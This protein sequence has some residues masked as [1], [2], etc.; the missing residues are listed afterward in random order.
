M[1]KKQRK[2]AKKASVPVTSYSEVRIASVLHRRFNHN[3]PDYLDRKAEHDI[4]VFLYNGFQVGGKYYS[5][6]EG[7][8]YLGKCRTCVEN[9]AMKEDLLLR[10]PVAFKVDPKSVLP[11]GKLGGELHIIDPIQLLTL[12]RM[13]DNN[14]MFKRMQT[15]LW[16]DEQ[17]N[18]L[19]KGRCSVKAWI[20][21]G[22]DQYWRDKPIHPRHPSLK[23][24]QP[25][26]EWP[27]SKSLAADEIPWIM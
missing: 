27:A 11:K 14:K 15:W 23:F 9:F 10:Q 7:A 1:T 6:I 22:C 24:N 25:L 5:V 20:Y 26:L 19:V 18:P 3:T 21:L 2:L 16:M 8:D 17:K 12:D 13:M 4:P